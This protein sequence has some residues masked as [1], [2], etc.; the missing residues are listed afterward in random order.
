MNVYNRKKHNMT[1][2]NE[3]KAIMTEVQWITFWIADELQKLNMI[4]Y[5]ILMTFLIQ[6]AKLNVKYTRK[7]NTTA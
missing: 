2:D 4:N 6:N 3:P 7:G 1:Q 5:A